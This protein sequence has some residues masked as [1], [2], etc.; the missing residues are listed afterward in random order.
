MPHQK[1]IDFSV[2]SVFQ[3]RLTQAFRG[4]TRSKTEIAKE[5]GISKDVFI[6]AMNAGLL[7]STRTLIKIADYLELS[8]DYLLGLSDKN[9]PRKTLD[10]LSFYERLEQLKTQQTKNT[11]R[12][13]PKQGFPAVSFPHGDK[14]IIFRAS[15]CAIS[16]PCTFTLPSTD[17][18]QGN[19]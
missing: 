15:K 2:S 16:C 8:I 9:T 6:R 14:K 17:F 13:P 4:D 11:E 18:W 7:P 19:R 3:A 5:I 12:S 10:N 1:D